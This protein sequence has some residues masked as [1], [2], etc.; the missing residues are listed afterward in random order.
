MSKAFRCLDRQPLPL[1]VAAGTLLGLGLGL[2]GFW[3]WRS[4]VWL[5]FWGG[6]VAFLWYVGHHA[7][8]VFEETQPIPAKPKRVRDGS[9]VMMQLP[10]G[11]FRMGFAAFV[12]AKLTNVHLRKQ[13]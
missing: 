1:V 9:M 5:F 11:T 7:A 13:E 8:P 12:H 4:P 6:L 10:G 3:Y 2:P